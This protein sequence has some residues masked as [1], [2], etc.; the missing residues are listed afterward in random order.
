[1]D[2]IKFIEMLQK[3]KITYYNSKKYKFENKN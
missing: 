1:M 2:V 3:Y